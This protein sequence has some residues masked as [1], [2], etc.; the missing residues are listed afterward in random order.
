MAVKIRV[1]GSIGDA[2][3]SLKNRDRSGRPVSRDGAYYANT[4]GDV[5]AI[6]AANPNEKDIY[7]DIDS[8]GGSVY[9]GFGM[10]DELRTSGRNIHTNIINGCHSIAVVLL[11]SAPLM[12][13]TANPNAR[14]L[15]HLVRMESYGAA[16][17]AEMEQAAEAIRTDE[18]RM[19]QIYT[20]RTKLTEAHAR[21]LI[22]AEKIHTVEDLLKMGFI[23]K[24][25]Q[26]K[27]NQFTNQKNRTMAQK[28]NE[29]ASLLERIGG[30]LTNAAKVLAPSNFNYEDAEGDVLFSTASE[31]DDL[32][33][34]MEVSFPD[35]TTGGTFE[36]PDGRIVTI[37]DFVVTAIDDGSDPDGLETENA[38]LKE[39]LAEAVALIAEMK[40]Q[41]GSSYQPQNRTVTRVSTASRSVRQAAAIAKSK[42]EIK[43]EVKTNREVGFG[44]R[45]IHAPRKQ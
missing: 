2:E 43:N 39:Q 42:D 22:Q 26:Y 7:I 5:T 31:S 45:G 33:V 34:G 29:G 18:N 3:Q 37:E 27:S 25:N 17:G 35:D 23:S 44:F 14:S 32:A 40:E 8:P 10:Y 9:D 28:R 13:R 19:I 12:R 20:E 6:L 16:T 36:L 30:F 1:F 15:M 11:L 4:T 24:I 41:I 38:A 21:R